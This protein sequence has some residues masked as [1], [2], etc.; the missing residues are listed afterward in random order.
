MLGQSGE[1]YDALT[2]KYTALFGTL[3]NDIWI[4]RSDGTNPK[5]D[6]WKVPLGYGP[7]EKWLARVV[8]DPNLDRDRAIIL[9]RISY[10]LKDMSYDASRALN[11]AGVNRVISGGSSHAVLNPVPWNLSYELSIITKTLED[12]FKIVEQILPF[13]RPD[14]TLSA[15]LLDSVPEYKKDISIVL[16]TVTHEDTY[17]GSF[18]DGRRIVWTLNFTLKGWYF[19]NTGGLAKV[20]KFATVD[21]YPDLVQTP[22]YS[23]TETW[24]GLTANGEPTTD[25]ATAI[26]YQ[27]VEEDDDWAYIVVRSDIIDDD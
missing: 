6:D 12:G 16:N 4:S 26:P 2:K 8:E 7:R 1:F 9:P 27:Q 17:E 13:F 23:K 5:V 25:P 14:I 24:P 10:E 19:T 20:I 11:P 3:F 22:V 18:L 21:L 15:H